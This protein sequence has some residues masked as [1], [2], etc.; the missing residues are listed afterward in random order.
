MNDILS[1]LNPSQR[2]AVQTIEGPVL[3]LAGPGSGKTRVIT[4]RIA[5]LVRQVGVAPHHIVAVT[6]T[7]KAAREMRERLARLLGDRTRGLIVG[8]FHATC[9][10][11]LRRDIEHLGRDSSFV[12]YD[13]DDQ[14]ALVRQVLKNLQLSDRQYRPGALLA[15]ISRAKSEMVG[16]AEFASSTQSYWEEVC[17]RVYEH[18]QTLLRERNALDF[19]DLLLTTVQLYRECPDVLARTQKRIVHLLVDEFQDTNLVQYELVKLWGGQYRNVFVVGDEDQCIVAGTLIATGEG[20]KPVESLGPGDEIIAAAGHC[21]VAHKR[22]D[23]CPSRWYNGPV[24]VVTTRHGH[25]LAATP[26]HCVFARFSLESRY[27]HVYLMYSH[28][29]GYRIG[30]T[31]KVRTDGAKAYPAF[32]ERLRQER[33]DAI[34]LLKACQ[35]LAEAAYWEAFYSARYGLPTVCFHAGG[36]R[37]AM[38]DEQI[39]RLYAHLDTLSAAERLAADLGLSLEYPHHVPQTTIRRGHVRKTVL[40]T[41]FGSK[42]T[43]TGGGRW[44]KPNDPWHLHELSICSS[45]PGFRQQV[46]S[47]LPTR[48]HKQRY[49]AARR[50]HGDYDTMDG[51]LAE[52]HR[53]APDARIWK[54]ARLTEH[55]Y[56]FMPIGHLLPG[57]MVPVLEANGQIVEDEVTSVTTEQYEGLVY[58]LSVPIY[59]NYVAGGIVVHNSIYRFRNADIANIQRRFRQDFPERREIILSRNYRSTRTILDA[60]QAVI[61]RNPDRTAKQLVTERATGPLITVYEAYD[62]TEEADYVA[63]EIA[64]LRREGCLQWGD[65]AVMYRTN[66]Q[67]R[68]LEDAF[69]R[70]GIPYKLV[71]GTRFYQRRE[72]KDILAYLRLA[73]N[74]A[75]EGALERIVNVPRRGIGQRTLDQLTRWARRLDV[76]TYT[77]LQRLKSALEQGDEELPISP[78]AARP[79]LD[80]LGLLEEL[81][82][83]ARQLAL[84]ELLDLVLERIAYRD[85]IRDG[86]EEGESRW[87]NVQ[88]LR[89]VMIGYAALPPAEGLTAFLEEVALVSDVDE[90]EEQPQAVTLLTLHMAK[91]LEFPAVFIVG[92]EE[93]LLPHIR[94]LDNPAQLAEERRLC[95]V[96]MTRAR[97]YLYL[98]H[99][100]RRTLYGNSVVNEASRFLADLPAS[101]ITGYRKDRHGHRAS[102]PMPTVRQWSEPSAP[103]GRTATRP[104][105]LTYKAGDKVYH[106]KFGEGIVI[107]SELIGDDEQVSVAFEGAGVRTLLASLALL[108]KVG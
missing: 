22:I 6:F 10:R 57:A 14:E 33:G 34:W 31:G 97:D 42:R 38:T 35:D 45:D 47:V 29:L 55:T 69:M 27:Y 101:L 67:S 61:A 106:S 65:V 40:F 4:H 70:R 49:W 12:I 66:A 51:T 60:A 50:I 79:L 53:T 72:V 99:A 98:L 81:V 77:A 86:T 93:G 26:E 88:E 32:M 74:P 43:K 76:N 46:E 95:Y 19:D 41:M 82:A 102:P 16:P 9:A 8:T 39:A 96:G 2:E 80:F 20:L 92:L 5:Y 94:S 84:P 18:Y 56:G 75:D 52:L 105:S 48:P 24:V 11:F 3:I 87:E 28:K 25:R 89:T 62:D 1:E 108:D 64:R 104:A 78:R 100:F 30:R 103:A 54:R 13:T 7:N 91:G 107:S 73:H 37:L 68:A 21:S 44:H 15:R 17:A 36:R 90:L 59:R 63:L 23:A 85:Y 83:A 58:D 71:G